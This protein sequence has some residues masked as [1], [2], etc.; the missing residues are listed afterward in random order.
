[1]SRVRATA[2]WSAAQY[3]KFEDERTRPARDLLAQVPLENARLAV[4]LGCGPAT[5]TALIAARFPGA[6]IV[7]VDSDPDMLAAARTRLPEAEY[8]AADL[9]AWKP[10]PGT[11][12]LYAN[13]VFQW[14]PDHLGVLAR[15]FGALSPA[16]V[17]AVQMPDN[18]DEP[19]LTL[20][21]ETARAGGWR[22][23]LA[24]AIESRV[25]LPP[26]GAYYDRLIG[27]AARVE[28]WHTHY[29]H[30]MAGPEAIVEWFKGSSLRPFLDALDSALRPSFLADYEARLAAAYPRRA[31]G[32][33][34][35]RFPRLFVIAVRG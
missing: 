21:R 7:G 31:D 24:A 8:V 3:L 16:A 11:D 17:L 27:A 12:L 5:S 20:M 32:S 14:V 1:V 15:L 13:A 25:P 28:V 19:A 10:E 9:R 22:D 4:D 23:S 29:Q 35:L 33:V 2:P 30:K 34:L 6:R 26:P 18:T